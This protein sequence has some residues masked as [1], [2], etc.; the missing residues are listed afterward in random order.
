MKHVTR[1]A[2]AHVPSHRWVLPGFS[3]E[4]DAPARDRSSYNRFDLPFPFPVAGVAR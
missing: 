2:G 1:Y 4:G 3:P